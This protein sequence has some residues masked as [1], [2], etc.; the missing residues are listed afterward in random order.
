MQNN[1][2]SVHQPLSQSLSWIRNGWERVQREPA[3][4]L[5]MT[6]VFLAIALAL[7]HIPFLGNFVLVLIAP[8][9]LASAL[10]AAR[11]TNTVP[12]P[13]NAQ[14][15]LRA[16]TLDA[17]RELFQ[18]FRR[19]DHT[20]AIVIVCIV[21]LGLV[22]LINIPELLITGGSVVSGLSGVSL[23]GPLRPGMIFGILV[24]TALYLVLTMA[25]LYVVPLT[26]FGNRQPVPAVAESFRA[27][28][29]HP[30]TLALFAAPFVAINLI[31][32]TAFSISH[33]SGYLLLVSLGILALPIF[34]I[35]L[36]ASYQALFEGAYTAPG[37]N[38]L[39]PIR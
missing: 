14:Q 31:V 13:Q 15:W 12:A 32:M 9:M 20:F 17:L 27:C 23:I 36:Q 10:L 11:S 19:E 35:G 21:T 22:V 29:E 25:L 34:V 2:T 26:L 4:W 16:L 8:I 24:V 38:T 33:W 1:D 18:V 6:L 5:G 37:T 28:L 3:R 39:P 30:K 7:K